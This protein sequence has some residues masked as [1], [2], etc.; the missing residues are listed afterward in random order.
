[1]G[2]VIGVLSVALEGGSVSIATE[3][4]MMMMMMP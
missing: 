2:G 1:M 4:T 3:V